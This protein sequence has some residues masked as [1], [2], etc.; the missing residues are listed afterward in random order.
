[1]HAPAR[2]DVGKKPI[3]GRFFGRLG[4]AFVVLFAATPVSALDVEEV[5]RL[6]VANPDRSA[7][8]AALMESARGD[9][10]AL[11]VRANPV[12]Q[13]Q[14]EATEGFGGTGTEDFF[15]L[16]QRFDT[17]G[18]RALAREAAAARLDAARF[19][20]AGAEREVAVAAAT[21]FYQVVA[22]ERIR[23][24]QDAFAA[25][26]A[27][28]EATAR[29]R[30][31][32]GDLS[33]YDVER[34]RQESGRV[35]ADV[36]RVGGEIT[37]ARGRLSAL[38]GPTA[39]PATTTL[40]GP[41]LPA[42]PGEADVLRERALQVPGLAALQAAANAAER[43]LQAAGRLVPDVTVGAGFKTVEGRGGDTGALLSLNV[44]LPLFD[45]RQG[46]I[47]R[48]AA[49]AG[50][51]SAR[52]AIARS[53]I[54]AEVAALIETCA[55]LRAAALTH[56]ETTLTSAAALENIA[57][58]AYRA[59]EIGVLE[60]IDA[61][62]TVFEADQRQVQLEHDARRAALQLERRLPGNQP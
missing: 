23:A 6:A 34:V 51:A 61:L 21:L 14:R 18:R 24:A 30:H 5:M 15:Q 26:L 10:T 44:P 20:A 52:L 7:V 43:D 22:A 1:M 39:W 13:Y 62:R 55:R 40:D 33:R 12:F 46:A 17:S 28:L 58:S 60:A 8:R 25:K 4:C 36:A 27:R 3:V 29:R 16:Q 59:G 38:L 2:F 37:A 53:E 54:A 57:R 48:S 31:E 19:Q 35:T 47:Q 11:E 32:A 42:P 45:R 9:L 56:R 49:E 50:A 41:L